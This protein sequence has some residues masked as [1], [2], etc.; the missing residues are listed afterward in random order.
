MKLATMVFIMASVFSACSSTIRLT[1][2]LDANRKVGGGPADLH[3]RSGL[4][5]DGRQVH[6]SQDSTRFFNQSNDSL[7]QL[8][9]RNIESIRVTHHG[10]GALEGLMFG[11]L[12]GCGV[13]ILAGIGLASGGDEGMGRGLLALGALT[14]GASCGLII[15]AVKG[16]DYTFIMPTDTVTAQ[17]DTSG[18]SNPRRR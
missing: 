1:S 14:L 8:P 10:G 3:L 15:G 2:P 4:T 16:H 18:I 11:G 7:I 13:G 5:Y 12:G 9:T 6:V 17:S